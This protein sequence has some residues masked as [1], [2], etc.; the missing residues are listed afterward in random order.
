LYC[1]SYAHNFISDN[2]FHT[3]RRAHDRPRCAELAALQDFKLFVLQVISP[4]YITTRTTPHTF[5]AYSFQYWP[6]LHS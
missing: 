2:N 3:N 4:I 6:V 5:Y 1:R